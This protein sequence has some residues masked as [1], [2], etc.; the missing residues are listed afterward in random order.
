MSYLCEVATRLLISLRVIDRPLASGQNLASG[1][2]P[3]YHSAKASVSISAE[4]PLEWS[5]SQGAFDRN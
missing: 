2:L 3:E 4:R 1:N 5:D